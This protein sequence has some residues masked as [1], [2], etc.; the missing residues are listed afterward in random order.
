M[1]DDRLTFEKQICISC[2][3][4]CLKTGLICKCYKTLGN[5]YAVLKQCYDRS[6]SFYAFILPFL[7]TFLLFV[8]LHLKLLDRAPNNIL[9]FLPDIFINLE[10]CHNIVYLSKLHKILHNINYPFIQFVLPYQFFSVLTCLCIILPNE[11]VL[12]VKQNHIIALAKKL[13]D[14]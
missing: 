13:Y 12:A 6:K 10:N 4:H 2:F 5:N 7:S 11:T 1:F 14:Q 8:T 9:F 3:Y